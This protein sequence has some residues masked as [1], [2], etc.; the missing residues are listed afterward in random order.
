MSAQRKPADIDAMRAAYEGG[1]SMGAVA[2]R[3]GVSESTVLKRL[4]AAGA[5]VRTGNRSGPTSKHLPGALP[6]P[7]L[8]C[9]KPFTRTAARWFQCQPCASRDDV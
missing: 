4:H 7:C 5:A 3:F 1:L 9:R 8:N 2:D 6:R